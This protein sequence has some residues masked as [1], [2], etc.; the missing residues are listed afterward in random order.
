MANNSQAAQ[1]PVAKASPMGHGSAADRL[2][3]QPT[4]AAAEEPRIRR[5]DGSGI[6]A[7]FGIHPETY[8]PPT[9]QEQRSDKR[10][11]PVAEAG[12]N[13]VAKENAE[14]KA[15]QTVKGTTAQSRVSR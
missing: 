14:L 15:A 13:N 2:P 8:V 7:G 3:A 11:E 6:A 1:P 12:K 9:P 4:A 5:Y 10:A